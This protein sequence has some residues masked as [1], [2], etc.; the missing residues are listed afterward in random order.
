MAKD[1]R[2]RQARI[3]LSEFLG[4]KTPKLFRKDDNEKNG[5]I[6]NGAFGAVFK[7]GLAKQG[8]DRDQ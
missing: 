8:S 6:F 1:F 3:K 2:L 4:S 7:I 5:I